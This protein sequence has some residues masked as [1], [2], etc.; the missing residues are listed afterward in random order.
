MIFNEYSRMLPL[1]GGQN[2]LPMKGEMKKAV[3]LI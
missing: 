3:F 2:E 1:F